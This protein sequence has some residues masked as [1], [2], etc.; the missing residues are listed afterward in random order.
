MNHQMKFNHLVPYILALVFCSFA[1]T[2]YSQ[3]KDCKFLKGKDGKGNT[4]RMIASPTKIGNFYVGKR[5]DKY[6]LSYSTKVIF[7]LAANAN[8]QT[9]LKID[10]VKFYFD[11]KDV[12]TLS[13]FG[14]GKIQNEV[15]LKY[16]FDFVQFEAPLDQTAVARFLSARLTDIQIMGEKD[17]GLHDLIVEKN[18]DKLIQAF[19]CWQ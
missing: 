13:A 14:V 15:K 1:A 5:E 17:S 6:F 18:Q 9:Q 11:N 2:A 8:N 10:S 7:L 4:I 19:T 16:T 12:V 3:K